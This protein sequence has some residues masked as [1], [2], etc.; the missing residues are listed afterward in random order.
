M[1]DFAHWSKAP[2]PAVVPE[3]PTKP[4][5]LTQVFCGHCGGDI[6][7]RQ[8]IKVGTGM[9]I[10]ERCLTVLLYDGVLFATPL[11]DISCPLQ[12]LQTFHKL[13]AQAKAISRQR[14]GSR[15]IH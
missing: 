3:L 9:G 13:Q 2:A 14:N 15:I 1:T 12:L 10:C 11:T 5:M 4:P 6:R 8:P 7:F